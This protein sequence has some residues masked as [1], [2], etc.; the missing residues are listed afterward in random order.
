MSNMNGRELF[1]EMSPHIPPEL[2]A[3]KGD[4]RKVA[5]GIS[6]SDIKTLAG[7]VADPTSP[8]KKQVDVIFNIFSNLPSNIYDTLSSNPDPKI[9]LGAKVVKSADKAALRGCANVAVATVA[10][11]K[12]LQAAAPPHTEYNPKP[13]HYNDPGL[14]D[15]NFFTSLIDVYHSVPSE[16]LDLLYSEATASASSE[17]EKDK[18]QEFVAIVRN[19]MD[20][21]TDHLVRLLVPLWCIVVNVSDLLE[22]SEK[23][24]ADPEKQVGSAKQMNDLMELGIKRCS[25]HVARFHHELTL[26]PKS[27]QDGALSQLPEDARK[28]A[29]P[30]L[31]L[32]M[33]MIEKDVEELFVTMAREAM[34]KK[35]EEKEPPRAVEIHLDD[36]YAAVTADAV[37]KKAYEDKFRKEL[38]KSLGVDP[39]RIKITGLESGSV[40]VKF[41]I[42]G[43][44]DE[45]GGEKG[46]DK[47]S[48][49]LVEQLQSQIKDKASPIYKGELL[50]KTKTEVAVKVTDLPMVEETEEEK[51]LKKDREFRKMM[52][53]GLTVGKVIMRTESRRLAKWVRESPT[54]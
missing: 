13:H 37:Q 43:N 14:I 18:A 36:D 31:E 20:Q 28:A 8:S 23:W 29:E 19:I 30:V 7:L 3:V 47:T 10:K 5:E 26:L 15:A 24:D 17:D 9:V 50:S 54:R 6:A 32:T 39:S 41:E 34:P 45:D 35:H 51:K 2:D 4:L 1:D 22:T 33:G 49:V 12:A 53:K 46:A 21:P 11:Y 44:G 52:K 40:I 48:S 25:K 27:I 38:A 16:V 42:S